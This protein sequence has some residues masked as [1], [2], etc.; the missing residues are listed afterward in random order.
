MNKW[1]LPISLSLLTTAAAAQN[2]APKKR[3]VIIITSELSFIQ[4]DER[5]FMC[6]NDTPAAIHELHKNCIEI[7]KEVFDY[8][9]RTTGSDVME[10]K[11]DIEKNIEETPVVVP[12][13]KTPMDKPAAP[14]KVAPV[15]PKQKS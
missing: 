1:I 14:V 5:Y 11:L 4:F 13:A 7:R 6:D 12:K 2:I 8:A 3:N 9:L 15:V 10:M